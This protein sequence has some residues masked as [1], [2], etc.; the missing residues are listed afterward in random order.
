MKILALFLS[1]I[2]P[3]LT[4]SQQDWNQLYINT[5]INPD[6][7]QNGYSYIEVAP[8]NTLYLIE[9]EEI[10]NTFGNWL[11]RMKSYDGNSWNQI[12]QDLARNTANNESHVDFVISASNEFY[13]GMLD[14]IFKFNSTTQIW[15]SY[16]VPEYC[17]GLSANSNGEVFFIHRTQGASGPASSDL[18]IAQFDNGNVTILNDLA[19]DMAV[20]PRSVNS[21]NK[22][23]F[24][25]NQITVSLVAQSTNLIYVFSGDLTNGFVKL[26]QTA[27]GNGSTLFAD[28]GLSSMVV[29][30]QNDII[31]SR[32]TGNNITI[33]SYDEIN[34]AWIPFD[35]TGIGATSCNFNHLRYDNNGDLHLIYTGSNNTGFLFKFN[36][37]S[38][39]HVGPTSFWSYHTIT[40]LIKPWIAFDNSNLLHFVTGIGTTS[41]PL[42]IF[43]RNEGLTEVSENSSTSTFSFYPNPANSSIQLNNFS[44]NATIEIHD[45][46]GKLIN[47]YVLNNS[48][49]GIV[50]VSTLTPGS[51]V[52][53][54][55]HEGSM[56]LEKLLIQ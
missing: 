9:S 17:G 30:D 37:T 1:V 6:Q 50:D 32:K 15:E 41:F 28:L 12:G 33:V 25:T 42:Q 20:L 49:N 36:G 7:A 19:I 53:Y 10:A 22:I 47:S 24:S 52:L 21:S 29:S 31:L 55:V 56:Q 2:V 46:S 54:Y 23:I 4:Y 51:Y 44:E 3:I 18:R 35:T 45:I 11:I 40:S 13:L 39:E 5:N 38:W 48:V 34:D 43:S 16:Y 26:E 8:D 27:P 14:N